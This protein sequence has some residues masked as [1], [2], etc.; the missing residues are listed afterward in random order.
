MEWKDTE[1]NINKNLIKKDLRPLSYRVYH[2]KHTLNI[3]L[4]CMT[5]SEWMNNNESVKYG[6]VHS[7]YSVY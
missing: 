4:L 1:N 6:R 7:V 5:Q 3:C 2:Q